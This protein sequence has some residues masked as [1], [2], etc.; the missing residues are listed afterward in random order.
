MQRIVPLVAALAAMGVAPTADAAQPTGDVLVT[1]NHW[2][3][4]ADFIDP[5]TFPRL[6]RL[7]IVPDRQERMAQIQANPVVLAYYLLVQ[8]IAIHRGERRTGARA[9]PRA[10]RPARPGP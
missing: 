4:T 1:S 10:G 3:G 5:Q 6:L 7:N 2:D 8:Q 9:A